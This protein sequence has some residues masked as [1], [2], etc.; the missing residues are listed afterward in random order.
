MGSAGEAEHGRAGPF[1]DAPPPAACVRAGTEEKA[2]WRNNDNW[3]LVPWFGLYRDVDEKDSS[4]PHV[5]EGFF[6]EYR[7]VAPGVTARLMEE[8]GAHRARLFPANDTAG[9]DASLASM[10]GFGPANITLTV[11]GHSLG[12]PL[13][14]MFALDAENQGFT[15]RRVLLVSPPRLGN[16]A[17]AR[18][19]ERRLAGRATMLMNS[20]DLVLS[21]PPVWDGYQQPNLRV[22]LVSYHSECMHCLRS[23]W[24]SWPWATSCGELCRRPP[25]SMAWYQPQDVT[26]FLNSLGGSFSKLVEDNINHDGQWT[27]HRSSN[28][29]DYICPTVGRNAVLWPPKKDQH[30]RR[31]TAPLRNAK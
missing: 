2:Q 3:V 9:A 11:L 15:V 24:L 6:S 23:L 19:L 21:G 31:P 13:A 26:Y 8:V 20:L 22:A 10:R 18:L 1:R 14:T 27:R 17:M 25:A 28:F 16:A 30:P 4:Q 7:L 5:S 12:C 29:A